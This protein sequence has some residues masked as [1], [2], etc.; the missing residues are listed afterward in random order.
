MPVVSSVVDP[1]HEADPGPD[2]QKLN[3]STT[4]AVLTKLPCEPELVFLKHELVQCEF[5]SSCLHR[6]ELLHR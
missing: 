6:P 4:P 1:F 3:G 2:P 5:C